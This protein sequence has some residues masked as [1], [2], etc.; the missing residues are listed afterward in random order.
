MV[1][2]ASL[3]A[4]GA[5]GF[6]LAAASAIFAQSSHG[7]IASNATA[8]SARGE[9]FHLAQNENYVACY[10]QVDMKSVL[11]RWCP[12]DKLW[13]P[14]NQMRNFCYTTSSACAEAEMPQSWCIQCGIKD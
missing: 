7:Q 10:K 1:R 12:K 9:K 6:V 2:I 13:T 5:A 8:Q 11:F 14:T 4:L 3:L